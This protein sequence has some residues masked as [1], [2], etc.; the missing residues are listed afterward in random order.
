[1]T[2]T[3]NIEVDATC[4]TEILLDLNF[5][6]LPSASVRGNS[7]LHHIPKALATKA[8]LEFGVLVGMQVIAKAPK[9]QFPMV[10]TGIVIVAH[11]IRPID[12]DNLL[13]GYKP[14]VD[15]LVRAGV[16]KDDAFIKSWSIEL[17]KG[18]PH[19]DMKIRGWSG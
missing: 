7:R 12:G 13:I 6:R 14:F 16:L 18:K 11:S 19:T 4:I 8:E 2:D 17:L 1:M 9:I 5:D 10:A 3:M 15:G